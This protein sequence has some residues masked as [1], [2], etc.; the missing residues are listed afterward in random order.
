LDRQLARQRDS[1][2]RLGGWVRGSAFIIFLIWASWGMAQLDT[3]TISGTVSDQS[4]GAI[5][6][7]AIT[8]RNVETGIAR[9]L[10]TNA[11]GRYEA[12]ALPVG[13]YEVRASLTGFQT[14]VRSGI[15]LTVGR[16]AVVDMALQVGEVAQ[17]VTVTGE[18]SFVET[19]TATV[20][21]LVDERRVSEIPLN[22]RDLTQLAF[23][24]PGVLK[25][26]INTDTADPSVGGGG[27]KFSVAG[28]R[29][30]HNVY[31]L[32]GVSNSDVSGSAQSVAGAY[33]GAETVQ[34]FQVITNN[35]S[36]EYP[37]K[38]G[39]ILSAITKSGTN[40]FHGSCMSSYAMTTWTRPSGK[41]TSAERTPSSSAT[42]WAAPWAGGFCATRPSSLRATKPYGKGESRPAT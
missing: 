5:P 9:N 15:T 19:T 34:E 21:N 17:S 25:M 36:A 37:S 16:N 20:S 32:D 30:T 35:Y 31:L 33:E 38:P 2:R 41:T 1:V 6:G 18:A 3:G 7:A 11:A 26:A 24:Q 10:T 39:A 23:L 42:T 27:A 22:N 14:L 13:N 29:G 28:A 8:I 4:G 12:A 40:A